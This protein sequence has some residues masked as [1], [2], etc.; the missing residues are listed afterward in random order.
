MNS[1]TSETTSWKASARFMSRAMNLLIF[2]TNRSCCSVCSSRDSNS[3][4]RDTGT[5]YAKSHAD[6][7]GRGPDFDIIPERS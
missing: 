6:Q 2:C 4:T 7:R 5:Y 3:L 1:T